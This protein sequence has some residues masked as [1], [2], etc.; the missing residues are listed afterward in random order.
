MH[1]RVEYFRRR[2]QRRFL[3]KIFRDCS[4][5]LCRRS[6]RRYMVC[7]RS[8]A[9]PEMLAFLADP[10]ASLS[11]EGSESLKQGNTC[12]LWRTRTGR[13]TLV[14]KRYNIKGFTHRIGRMFRPTRAAATWKNAHRLAMCG[15]LTPKPVALVEERFGLLRG[16]AWYV[17][18]Y[19]QGDDA[20]V[21]CRPS[22]DGAVDVQTAAG[23]VVALLERLAHCRISHGDMKGNNFILS[24]Q[25]AAVIDLDAMKQH[26]H[27]PGFRRAQRRD[28]HRFMRNWQDC[29]E[30]A[31][32]FKK[33]LRD[34]S[35]VPDNVTPYTP[36]PS[37]GG[38]GSGGKN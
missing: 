22:A 10:D 35:L 19:L 32:M 9:S 31:A 26:V 23:S 5:F 27:E 4:A 13:H 1:E 11:R 3:K 28:L 25:G 20:L 37:G 14:V 12:T 33:L 36:S 7:D 17:S 2:R 6:L 38:L 8:M 30:T 21:L 24:R 29:P 15:I 16:R 18:E 34:N